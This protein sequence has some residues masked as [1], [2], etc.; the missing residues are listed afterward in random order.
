MAEIA[1]EAK[2]YFPYDHVRPHQNEFINVIY[3]AVRTGQSVLIEG[4]NGLGKTVASLSACLPTAIKNNLKILYVARTHR[5]HDRV[6]EELK[7][8]S[9]KRSVSGICIR[10]R[11]EMCLNSLVTR[12]ISDARSAMEACEFLKSKKR[13]KYYS[14]IEEKPDEYSDLRL[15]ITKN[16]QNAYEIQSICKGEGFCSYELARSSLSE[17]TVIALSYMYVFDPGIRMAFLKNLEKSLDRVVLIID[18]AHNLPE[19]AVE[20]ASSNLSLFTLRQAETEAKEFKY[21]EIA[22]FAATVIKKIELEAKKIRNE[23]LF[24]SHYL[25]NLLAENSNI[26]DLKTFFEGVYSTGNVI[27]RCLLADGRHPR[28]F[29]HAMGEF[30]LTLIRTLDDDAFVFAIRKYASR[31]GIETARLEIISLDPS[32]ITEP[33]FSAS[34]SNV[35]MSGTLQ[36]LD[37]FMKVTELPKESI[38][39]IVPSPFPREHVLPLICCGVST[40][41]DKRNPEMYSKIVKRIAEVVSHTPANCGVFAASFEVLNALVANGLKRALD[42]PLFCEYRNMSSKEN[43]KTVAEFKRHSRAGGA[44]LLGVQGGRS[45]EGVD[46][47]GDQ[48]NS[49]VIVGIPYAEPTPRIKA[50]ISFFEKQFPGF[51]REYAYVIP[52]MKKSSQAAGRPI[53]TLEDLG[54]MIFMDHRFSTPYCRSFLP[55][56]IREN[57]K[58]L[59]D[60][61]GALSA[62]LTGFFGPN[63]QLRTRERID[64][65]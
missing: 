36:P 31:R 18:E 13:C 34:W 52:A 60:A 35:V 39:K 21:N 45:S 63:S 12:H 30:F 29:V 38:Q 43:E 5:Q 59:P 8:I 17:V 26:K 44:V 33:V 54:A 57:L 4:S 50:Q 27:K 16:L 53:R 47:P 6:I 58:I 23:Q 1:N 55:L 56:W 15:Q 28:S 10:G 32:R 41:M 9:S 22:Q 61:E 62:E 48:M 37:A 51:G 19:T 14:R 42:K 11:Q 2:Q 65:K 64:C 3:E 49:A 40:A 46:F 24:P 25:T 20:I 7:S